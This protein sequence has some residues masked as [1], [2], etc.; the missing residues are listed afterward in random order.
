MSF[1][2]IQESF[3]NDIEDIKSSGLWKTERFINSDQSN[4]I[5]LADWREV[6]NMCANNYLGLANN[7]RVIEAAKK[8]LDQWGF[9]LASVRFICGTQTIHKTLEKKVSEFL[10]MEDT[11]LYAA[12]FDA[13]GGLFETILGAEDAVI[14][15]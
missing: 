14:S 6:V 10:G 13:N 4:L 8:S 5:T 9:G 1:K 11:I 12:C 7:K 15:D 3:A 2:N